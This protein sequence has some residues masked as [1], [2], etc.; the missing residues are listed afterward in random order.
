MQVNLIRQ[1]NIEQKNNPRFKGLGDQFFR[2]LATNQAVGANS[3]DLGFMV[4]P[5]TITDFSGRGP[6]AGFETFRREAAGTTNHTLIGFYGG[7]VGAALAL[8]YGMKG[9]FGVN[10]D[11]MYVAPET[12]NILAENKTWQIK[13]KKEQIDYIKR[14]LSNLK[15]YNPGA[16]RADNEGFVKLSQKTI[17]EVA[18]ILEKAINTADYKKFAGT[19]SVKNANSIELLMNKIIA[20][21]G[22]ESTYLLSLL[23]EENYFIE[24]NLDS[25]E[26]KELEHRIRIVINEK[27]VSKT[28]ETSLKTFLEDM[29]KV[30]DAFNKDKVKTCF[31][32]QI[33]SNLPIEK[34][35]FIHKVTKFMSHRSVLGLMIASGIG[36]S[37]QP[38]NM[39]LTKK[40]TGSD[41]FV[42]V[43]GRSKDDSVGFKVLKGAAGLGFFGVVLGALQTGLKGFM[44]KMSFK[45]FWPTISQLKGVYGFTIISRL[46]SARDKDELRESLTKDFLGYMSWLVLGDIVNKFVAQGIDKSV[47]NR[48]DD[49]AKKNIFTKVFK[50]K[51]KTRDEVLIEGLSRNGVDVTKNDGDKV[52]AKKFKELMKD[53]KNLSNEAEKKAIKKQLRALNWAQ[54]AGYAFSGLVLGV[55]I[56]KL[57]IYITNMLDKKRKEKEANL[58]LQS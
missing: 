12:L 45:G 28:S 11:K 18:E 58:A 47:M 40:K 16:E 25:I 48:T 8:L 13:N 20:D 50:S 31:E 55:G 29:F 15:G 54:F 42:G 30:S 3:V 5:R 39:Y 49:I 57:N 53:L 2:F 56:P 1:N 52:V 26:P 46:I 22:A 37:V 4:L 21:T 17:D 41:G 14:T 33:S 23:K 34:N 38:I 27:N 9:K 19:G 44:S 36:M 7:A 32:E 10:V 24:K 6:E 51:L 35:K 43:E